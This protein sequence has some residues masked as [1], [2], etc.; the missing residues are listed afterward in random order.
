MYDRIAGEGVIAVRG[1]IPS[2]A[3]VGLA[4]IS[5]TADEAT[6]ARII[7]DLLK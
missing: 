1:D 5:K 2:D 6:K 3:V 7:A 4:R